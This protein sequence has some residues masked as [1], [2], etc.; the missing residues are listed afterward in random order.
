MRTQWH[1]SINVQGSG[2]LVTGRQWIVTGGSDGKG[3]GL[4]KVPVERR[5]A[6]P[7]DQRGRVRSGLVAGR[8]TD[9]VRGTQS[10]VDKDAV[11]GGATRWLACRIPRAVRSIRADSAFVSCPM[12]RVWCTCRVGTEDFWLL[13]L[14]SRK[15]RPIARLT[16]RGERAPST[17]HRTE[18]RL[19][20]TACVR[21]RTSS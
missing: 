8:I 10:S 6:G 14:Q 17:S 7:V 5:C 1:Q 9:R 12:G 16:A 3:P 15:T 20:S 11:P 21:T 4:F 2:R 13:D 19:S 18:S